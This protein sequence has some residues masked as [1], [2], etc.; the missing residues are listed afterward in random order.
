[1]YGTRDSLIVPAGTYAVRMYVVLVRI[2]HLKDVHCRDAFST[3]LPKKSLSEIVCY[4]FFIYS[5]LGKLIV[6]LMV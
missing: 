2:T 5:M 4:Y 3:L 1:M 6:E